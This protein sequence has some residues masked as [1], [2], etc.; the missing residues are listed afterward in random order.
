MVKEILGLP[1]E[2]GFW[3]PDAVLDLYRSARAPRRGAPP[4]LAGAFRR[5]GRRQGGLARP[6]RPA[7]GVPGW[8]SAPAHVSPRGRSRS[9]PVRPSRRAST[10]PQPY[11]PGLVPGGAPI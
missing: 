7:R 6:P 10:P 4:G 11:I 5:L 3:V 8:E 2:V 9:P 1:P